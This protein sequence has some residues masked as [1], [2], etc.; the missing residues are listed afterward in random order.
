V[1]AHPAGSNVLLFTRPARVEDAAPFAAQMRSQDRAEWE[2][3]GEP[4]EMLAGGIRDS[5][6]CHVAEDAEGYVAIWGTHR[7]TLLGGEAY[8]WCATTP[9]VLLHKRRFLLGS[10]AWLQAMQAE[11]DLIAGWCAAD[12]ALS[13]RWLHHWLGFE[14]GTVERLGP[15]GVPFVNFW[16]RRDL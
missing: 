13:L 14:L 2:A 11:Y 5:W 15:L 12:Y 4:V 9:R 10:R 7:V 8:A 16:W 1:T 6:Q 3:I